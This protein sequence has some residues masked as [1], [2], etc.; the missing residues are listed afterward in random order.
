MSAPKRRAALEG[1]PAL[2]AEARERR[3]SWQAIV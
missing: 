3:I 2:A 1:A